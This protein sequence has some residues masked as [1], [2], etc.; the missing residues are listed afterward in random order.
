MHLAVSEIQDFYLETELG[1]ITSQFIND[2][3][4]GMDSFIVRNKTE[5]EVLIGYGYS[6]PYLKTL[7]RNSSE[8][9]YLMSEHQGTFAWLQ[10]GCNRTM[11][12]EETQWP[13]ESEK[14]H[15][16]IMV[17]GLETCENPNDLLTEAWR[18]LVPE[19][20][21]LV[22][23]P[24]RS[25]FWARSD[26]TPFGNGRPYSLSQLARLLGANRFQI[27]VTQAALFY[28]PSSKRFFLKSSAL[29]ERIGKKYA[30]RVMGGVI[31]MLAKKQIHA[32]TTLKIRETIKVPLGLFDGLIEPKPKPSSSNSS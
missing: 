1:L 9:M 27:T 20:Y 5:K 23:V 26:L 24:N 8:P 13:L 18:A 17:H 3:I 21:L 2:A 16:V 28:P 32:P 31:I 29:L 14:A 25:G 11:L 30:T 22:V 6:T 4:E 12:V 19:G 7:V 15:I 10:S